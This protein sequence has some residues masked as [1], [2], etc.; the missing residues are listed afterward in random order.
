MNRSRMAC[1]RRFCIFLND[2]RNQSFPGKGKM[3]F[4]MIS[5]R[6]IPEAKKNA[7]GLLTLPVLPA[8][9][10]FNVTTVAFSANLSSAFADAGSQQRVL[11]RIL[12]GF[13]FHQPAFAGQNRH[14]NPI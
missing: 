11:F 13:P 8:F 14:L 1:I 4:F 12:T 6:F 7:A 9:P 10:S 3:F 2:A 5:C